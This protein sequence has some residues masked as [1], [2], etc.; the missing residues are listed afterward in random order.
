VDLRKRGM[1][2]VKSRGRMLTVEWG[3]RNG[4]DA[5]ERTKDERRKWQEYTLCILCMDLKESVR[6]VNLSGL[7]RCTIH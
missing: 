6:R 4:R 7:V 3:H 1:G 2:R 5:K